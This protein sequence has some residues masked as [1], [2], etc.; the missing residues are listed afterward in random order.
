MADRE[1][2][3]HPLAIGPTGAQVAEY[4]RRH[5]N[6]LVEHPELFRH[7]TPPV[8]D[9]GNGVVDLQH[10]MLERLKRDLEKLQSAQNDLIALSRTNL[11]SQTRVHAAIVA[12][13]GATTLEHLIEV[14]TTD[15]AVHL[16]VDVVLLGFEASVQGSETAGTAGLKLLPRN[17]VDRL[18]P[19][20]KPVLLAEDEPPDAAL[21]GGAASLVRSQALLRLQVRPHGPPGLLAFGS[22]APG[23]FHSGQGTELLTFL[24]RV[25]ELSIR[26]WLSH[27]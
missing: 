22:R 12:L 18:I 5:P 10:Y 11:I 24:A 15:F 3:T 27:P 13:L 6:F 17:S 16:D 1:S 23:R 14:V 4:L 19:G 7:L 20:A 2:M 25:V 9:R 26:G 21:F 8:A